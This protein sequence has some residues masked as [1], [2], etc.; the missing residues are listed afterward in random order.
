MWSWKIVNELKLET[1]GGRIDDNAG[2]IAPPHSV[3]SRQIHETREGWLRSRRPSNLTQA[4]DSLWGIRFGG[5][6]HEVDDPRNDIL[7]FWVSGGELGRLSWRTWSIMWTST[8][9]NECASEEE[10]YPGAEQR[11]DTLEKES[12]HEASCLESHST[13]ICAKRNLFTWPVTY[14]I[15]VCVDRLQLDWPEPALPRCGGSWFV[16]S[17][18]RPASRCR[19]SWRPPA[20]SKM[21]SCMAHPCEGTFRAGRQTWRLS[22]CRDY[23]ETHLRRPPTALK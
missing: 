19:G 22:L 1:L 6:V 13:F 11:V 20:F 12:H 5:W 7:N 16:P 2:V 18:R 3:V 14:V 15:W 4:M 23:K 17:L 8:A 10:V 9:V 21:F